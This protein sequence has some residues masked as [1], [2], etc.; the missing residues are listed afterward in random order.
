M[1]EKECTKGFFAL[2]TVVKMDPQVYRVLA[3]ALVATEVNFVSRHV[4]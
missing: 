2:R 3:V 1:V 4:A